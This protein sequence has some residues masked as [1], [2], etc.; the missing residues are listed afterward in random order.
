MELH[1]SDVVQQVKVAARKLIDEYSHANWEDLIAELDA[2]EISF[3]AGDQT[4]WSVI[5]TGIF[6]LGDRFV[7]YQHAAA[8]TEY[9]DNG[10]LEWELD[11]LREV[12]PVEVMVIKYVPVD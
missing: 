9:Q 8:A 6:K 11:S 4:R 1:V 2:E 5:Y 10:E 7:Q 3:E 12:K